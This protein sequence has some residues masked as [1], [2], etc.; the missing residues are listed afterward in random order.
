MEAL[1]RLEDLRRSEVRPRSAQI[2]AL[3]VLHQG[4]C[5]ERE[6]QRPTLEDSGTE[7]HIYTTKKH[8]HTHATKKIHSSFIFFLF[9]Y[10]HQ[11]VK[12][13]HPFIPS[14]HLFFFSISF[15]HS[16]F[17]V[18]SSFYSI[19]YFCPLYCSSVLFLTIHQSFLLSVL[20]SI[21]LFFYSFNPFIIF[22]L[23]IHYAIC[24][25]CL[26][27][28]SLCPTHLFLINPSHS[29]S[30]SIHLFFHSF[31]PFI[32][33]QASLFIH[34]SIHPFLLSFF[35]SLLLSRSIPLSFSCI[36][37]SVFQS[38]CCF[39]LPVH[40]LLLSISSFHSSPSFPSSLPYRF[41]L[42]LTL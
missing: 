37:L 10:I 19:H 42:Q 15:F 11:H 32:T 24:P 40:F 5:S 23:S 34:S 33:C 22:F 36:S 29:F 14:F 35:H 2:R 7:P 28:A 41:T 3:P 39:I 27:I 9:L 1:L 38:I 17:P 4:K 13:F 16:F 31:N 25:I 6:R 26:S 21:C 12:P 20:P 8:T 18:F 30:P